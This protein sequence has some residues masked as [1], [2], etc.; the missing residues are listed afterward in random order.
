MKMKKIGFGLMIVGM[1]CGTIFADGYRQDFSGADNH[2]VDQSPLVAGGALMWFQ[3]SGGVNSEIVPEEEE[4]VFSLK[5]K[6]NKAYG[7][8]VEQEEL[9]FPK[10]GSVVR[11]VDFSMQ[12][13]AYNSNGAQVFGAGFFDGDSLPAASAWGKVVGLTVQIIN[14]NGESSFVIRRRGWDSRIDSWDGEK[15]TD[16]F[17]IPLSKVVLNQSYQVQAK[18]SSE[19]EVTLMILE[20]GAVLE[21]ATSERKGL[22]DKARDLYWMVG[23]FNSQN[24]D[25]KYEFTLNLLERN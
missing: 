21:S 4:L 22:Y 12:K 6:G 1:F 15:W 23:D 9:S 8:A 7:F 10:E 18:V 5:A 25:L 13:I 20:N 14:E 3:S 2:I 11:T 17:T 24:A 19:D 16:E